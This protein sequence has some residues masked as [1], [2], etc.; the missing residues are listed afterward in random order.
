M[1]EKKW[2]AGLLGFLFMANVV[3]AQ[4]NNKAPLQGKTVT[5]AKQQMSEHTDD[6]RALML[7]LYEQNPAELAKSTQVGAREMTEWVFDGKANWKFDGIRGLQKMQAIE[8]VFEP[9][10]TGD[11]ILALVAGIETL[12]FDAYGGTNEFEI[13]VLQDMQK[14]TQARCELQGFL[15][16]ITT[17]PPLTKPL[18]I[19]TQAIASQEIQHTVRKV[20]SRMSGNDG[21]KPGQDCQL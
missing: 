1:H 8:L 12:L 2:L 19:L 3:M 16:R 18:S 21:K 11:Q 15:K 9:D 5:T 7:T 13:P 20:I 17:Q 10:F 6:L 4:P 14:H